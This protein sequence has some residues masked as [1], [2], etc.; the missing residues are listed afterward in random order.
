MKQ[1][2]R[3][4]NSEINLLSEEG[5][6]Q[7]HRDHDAARAFFL[8]HVNPNTVFFH[9][10]KEK[11]DY[12]VENDLWKRETVE[13]YS[14]DQFKALFKQAYAYKFRFQSFMGAYKFYNQYALKTEDGTRYYERYEDRV[15]MCA[16]DLSG[17]DYDLARDLVDAI[18]GGYFQPATPTF[19][20]AGRAQGGERV[21][22]FLLRVEDNME[23]IGRAIN[24]SLQLS[25]RG[26]GVGINLSNLRE[27]SAPIKNIPNTSSGVV[28][29]MKILEDSFSY[30][31]QLGQRQGAGAVYLNAHHPD[32]M[33][34]LDTKRENADEKVRIKTLSLGVI[35]PDVTF[36]LAKK[37]ADMYLFSPYDVER[38]EGK[39]FADLSV[40]EHYHQWVEDD[41]ITKT[42]INARQFFQTLSE[43]QF[44]S[45]YPYCLFEDTANSDHTM[46]HAGRVQ[47][48]N[49]CSEILQLQTP[50][51]YHPDGSY[52]TLG[53]DISC[54]LGS[55][56]VKRMLDLDNEA[57]GDVV[58]TAVRALDNVARTTEIDS[59][60]S[61]KAGNDR[62]KAIGLGQMNLHGALA[63]HGIEYGS[64]EALALWDR[65]M[66][67]VTFHAM[68]TSTDIARQHGEH[69]YFDGSEYATGAWFERKIKP[70]FEEDKELAFGIGELHA[71][72]L[73]DWHHLQL[74]V[75]KHG[76]A[77]AYLQAIPP[78][79]SIS[80]INHSTASIHPV[81]API[82]IRKE[83]R[84]GRV[85]YPA[86]H[87]T[88][89]NVHLY[90]DAYQL[91]YEKLIDT[92]AVS[93]YWV[94][95]GSSCTLFFPDTAT[96]R[97]VD[98]ARI[99]A[100]RKGIKTIYY[101]RIKQKA[102]EGTGVET[103]A[104]Y[105]EACQL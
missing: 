61:V 4:I 11:T 80:Y 73:E 85:Y 66:A 64:E 96:T 86:P 58:D 7:L 31:N 48:S 94:D 68:L 3:D 42:K 39:T 6:L 2:Y 84:T 26:G 77:N 72:T 69:E 60:P 100:W 56:N 52:K 102:L 17:G 45:G 81:V 1:T 19:L 5:K 74:E 50:S 105:C 51:E 30:A 62:S 54:N 55:L 37:N 78:T 41:R 101:V 67:K 15:V 43:L 83:G 70:W 99:Y 29:V 21:S 40:T 23:S 79:G 95:Q 44:E 13:T 14:F 90:K 53:S 28:P 16:I 87:M 98:R 10:L 57:F 49:L 27:T 76:M 20:N 8:E 9:N 34:A 103:A 38:V 33:R 59:V 35:I 36:E 104:D 97:D 47:M 24:S 18:I 91:G 46:G 71:P 92:Y 22:C 63:H 65:Y 32:I 93:T 82:E 88:E 75:Y 25:K 12:L 89:D